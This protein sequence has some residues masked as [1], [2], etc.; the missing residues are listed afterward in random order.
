MKGSKDP[1]VYPIAVI[2]QYQKSFEKPSL[3]EGLANLQK[4]PFHREMMKLISLILG[5]SNQSGIAKGEITSEQAIEMFV[6]T[7][8]QLGVEI[9]YK[10]CPHRAFPQICWC[11]KPIPGLGVEFIEKLQIRFLSMHNGGEF[12]DRWDICE[13]SGFPVC[14]Q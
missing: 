4:I 7:N 8:Q 9:E 2:F 13:T 12:K 11:R 6:S 5:V 10:F 1:G 14:S 3:N